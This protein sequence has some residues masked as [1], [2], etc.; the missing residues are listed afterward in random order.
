MV[1]G[2]EIIHQKD[3]LARADAT[4]GV[5]MVKLSPGEQFTKIDIPI[6]DRGIAELQQMEL[7]AIAQGFEEDRLRRV[8]RAKEA[9]QREQEKLQRAA[10][11]LTGASY[12]PAPR[13]YRF[14]LFYT[15]PLTSICNNDDQ[16]Y[17]HC[18]GTFERTRMFQGILASK[19]DPRP[20]T[21]LPQ[22]HKPIP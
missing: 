9:A 13:P 21:P 15:P 2:A 5:K 10:A 11:S 20:H 8:R 19:S 7:D 12:K 18:Q 3:M 16:G 17:H 14:P 1:L 22:L 4:L 6:S